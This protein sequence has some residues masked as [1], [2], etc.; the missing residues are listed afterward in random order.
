MTGHPFPWLSSF[1]LV[2]GVFSVVGPL[3]AF[4]F[5]GSSFITGLFGLAVAAVF[6]ALGRTLDYLH[7][8]VQRQRR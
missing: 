4:F 5:G 8:V 1:L 3:F 2:L 7:E 6:F